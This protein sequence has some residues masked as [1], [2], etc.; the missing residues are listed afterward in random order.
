[1]PEQGPEQQALATAVPVAVPN[2]PNPFPLW[3]VLP[4]RGS[5]LCPPAGP[6]LQNI[7]K[8]FLRLWFREHCDPYNDPVRAGRTA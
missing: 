1:M 5:N 3:R 4:T 2:P 8:E 6:L 7:D